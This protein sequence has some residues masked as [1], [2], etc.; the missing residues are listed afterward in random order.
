MMQVERRHL[1]SGD[2]LLSA[3]TG[4]RMAR[5]RSVVH[6]RARHYLVVLLEDIQPKFKVHFGGGQTS[7]H[8]ND[9]VTIERPE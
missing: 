4:E 8:K 6:A 2:W 3:A 9:M 5:V 7:G 1:Q